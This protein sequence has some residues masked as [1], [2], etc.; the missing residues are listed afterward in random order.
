M[1]DGANAAWLTAA[2]GVSAAAA[3]PVLI[4][5]RRARR[6]ASTVTRRL[7]GLDERLA[8]VSTAVGDGL[9]PRLDKLS[10]E[11][12]AVSTDLVD[13][14]RTSAAHYD[15]LEAYIDL[16][17][18]VRPRAPMPPLRG[19][20]ASPDV[21]RHLTEAVAR[22]RPK[23]IVECGSGSSSVWLGYFAEQLA[24]ARVVCLEHD[25]RYGELSR[26]LIRAH[27][28]ERVVEIRSAPLAD[29]TSGDRAYPWYSVEALEDLADIGVLFVDGPPAATG[30]EARYP[31]V[32]LLLSRCA[33][34]A[35]IVLDD[36]RRAEETAIS[37]RW[38]AEHP[39]IERTVL[40]FEKGA[41]VFT[42]RTP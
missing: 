11:V 24:S 8:S 12:S 38:L 19:W 35:V 17:S 9:R 7:I 13:L 23:L 40:P 15:Q 42:R 21:L 3:V 28:L 39:E 4:V 18:L 33:A 25:E 32:P 30:P 6:W 31:A 36:S 16:R 5:L 14:A 20:A 29:W 10:G 37:D 1:L 41:H 34:D 22:R 26:E 2:V 27:G